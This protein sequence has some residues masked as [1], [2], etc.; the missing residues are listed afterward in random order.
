ML[1]FYFCYSGT[2]VS[3]TI[4][5]RILLAWEFLFLFNE[6]WDIIVF[7]LIILWFDKCFY[8][9]INIFVKILYNL[10]YIK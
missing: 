1:K 6:M 3:V 7:L 10:I 4:R 9:W 2:V 5:D 8:V